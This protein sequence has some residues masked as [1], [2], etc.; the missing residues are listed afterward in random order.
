MKVT[1]FSKFG[2]TVGAAALLVCAISVP[3]SADPTPAGSFGT[4]VGL[5]S[6][7]TQDVLNGLATSIGG[8]KL[9]S[10]DATGT[11]STVVTRAGANPIL[12][13]RASGSGPGRD[14][15]R[16]SIGQ[17]TNATI[18]VAPTG[19]AA[20]TGANSIGQIDFARSSSGPATADALPDGV[21]AYVPFATDA[22]TVAVDPTSP[23]AKIPSITLGTANDAAGVPSLFNI[24][25][26]AVRYVY[27]NTA[28]S[29][30]NSVGLSATGPA[31]T[32]STKISPLLPKA[33]SGTRSYFIGKV[34]LTEAIITTLK[35]DGVLADTYGTPAV[36]VQEHD[37]SAVAGNASAIVPFS[38]GQWV[39]QANTVAPDRRH[40]V[41]LASLNGTAP[42]TGTGTSYALN[43]AYNAMTR[44]VYNIVPSKLADDA[45]SDIAKTFVGTS[46]LVCKDTAT[47][48]KY[49][50]GL[51]T[52]ADG[53]ATGCGNT[54]T[55]AYA[56]TDST[57]AQSVSS[58]STTVGGTVTLSAT[59]TST[60]NGGG[61]V[62]FSD[63]TT[64]MALATATIA[65]GQTTGSVDFSPTGVGT[66]KVISTFV[67]AL[68]GVK[69][70]SV[71]TPT[72]VVVAGAP[73]SIAISTS[74]STVVGKSTPVIAWVTSPD[75]R[76]GTVALYDG[77]TKIT[78]KTL[79]AGE[80]GAY[81]T[82]TPTKLSYNL[83]VR[84]TPPTD[85]TTL[86]SASEGRTVVATQATATIT[87][88]ATKTIKSTV[89]GKF[90]VTVKAT[91]VT[92]TGSVSIKEGSKVLASSKAIKSGK[93]TVTLP[94]LKKG[95]HK[96]T[97]TYNGSE[98]VKAGTKTVTIKVVK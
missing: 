50:F 87:G 5:G 59:V 10:Y 81:L 11:T 18:A 58:A 79:A 86:A 70:S 66:V 46:S 40:G 24:Y 56:G 37:G 67:P 78:S 12:V 73:S 15:L 19:T 29:T 47:I 1:T 43:P 45:S 21:L 57:L 53:S 33:G 55:R 34:G 71:T 91:G 44:P 4:L 38:I 22:V 20:V 72:D 49:G 41:V 6:D 75:L 68:A 42:T 63:A 92:P 48:T 16:V 51:M 96:L 54:I 61:S 27:L 88:K 26:G 74:T 13:P 14:L 30:Y 93:L 65:N 84:Y 62:I 36:D 76:G 28:D 9:A 8:G 35:A 2:V 23:L 31:N 52:G 32:T 94:K 82:F 85:S 7:T 39:A 17:T 83:I 95:S 69:S 3:A 80:N 64:K 97:I 89:K 77:E 60:N 98:T 25:K 90:A